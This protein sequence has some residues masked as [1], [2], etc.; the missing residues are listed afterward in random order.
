MRIEV[1][2]QD[3]AQPGLAL[4]EVERRVRQAFAWPP[5]RVRSVSVW[6]EAARPER[7]E[8]A[9]CQMVLTL[10]RGGCIVLGEAE[11]SV[12]AALGKAL[13]RTLRELREIAR[14]RGP[15]RTRRTPRPP[16]PPPASIAE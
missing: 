1:T 7:R 5:A 14:L 9:R 2:G 10:R 13:A 3:V 15:R 6:L 16:E 8:S 4:S 12:E 11:L